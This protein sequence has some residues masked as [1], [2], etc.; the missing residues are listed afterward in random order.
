MSVQIV[1]ENHLG[2]QLVLDDQYKC[3]DVSGLVPP[4]AT[5]NRAGYGSTDGSVVSSAYVRER[6]IVL[7]VVPE[8]SAEDARLALWRYVKPK[9]KVRLYFQTNTRDVLIDGYVEDVEGNPYSQK[10][11]YQISVICPQ[12]YFVDRVPSYYS[13]SGVAGGFTFPVAIPSAGIALGTL[14][15]SHDLVISNAGDETVG[16]QISL[17]ARDKVMYPVIYNRTAGTYLGLDYNLQAG[18]RIEIDTRS[19]TKRIS[20]YRDGEISNLLHKMKRGSSWITL[21]IGDNLLSYG[22]SSGAESM[23]VQYTVSAYYEGV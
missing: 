8:G 1:I 9:Y 12:P 2:Q 14:S 15:S 19:G 13:Q 7:T 3:I 10:A 17:T 21:G 4:T 16:V 23:E 5:V 6:N 20:L 11:R 22:S 18:D